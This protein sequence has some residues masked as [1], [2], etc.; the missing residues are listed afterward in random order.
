MKSFYHM[1]R[2][3]RWRLSRSDA[4]RAWATQGNFH[5]IIFRS[6]NKSLTRLWVTT[7][8]LQIDQ[9]DRFLVSWRFSVGSD[10]HNYSR[11]F[12]SP[13]LWPQTWFFFQRNEID[14]TWL[15]LDE[16]AKHSTK[17]A[18]MCETFL[19]F[20]PKVASSHHLCLKT[21]F[22]EARFCGA[23]LDVIG[24]HKERYIKQVTRL[25]RWN[26]RGTRNL[27]PESVQGLGDQKIN[28]GTFLILQ[29]SVLTKA[30]VDSEELR[31]NAHCLDFFVVRHRQHVLALVERFKSRF[32]SFRK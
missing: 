31:T 26:N 20:P 10:A 1:S 9:T 2:V 12:S 17:A 13:P 18:K 32:E 27:D 8:T 24:R 29:P 23:E 15:R 11:A 28:H 16:E 21:A 7:L 6:L 30:Q 19:K 4:K 14:I 3:A 25:S 5:E 22:H